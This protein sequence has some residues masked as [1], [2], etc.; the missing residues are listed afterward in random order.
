MILVTDD[1]VSQDPRSTA[2]ANRHVGLDIWTGLVGPPDANVAELMSEVAKAVKPLFDKFIDFFD[3]FDLSFFVSGATFVAAIA[4]AGL[5]PALAQLIGLE[6]IDEDGTWFSNSAVPSVAVAM[7]VL[8]S[9][10]SGMTCFALGRFVRKWVYR[11]KDRLTGADRKRPITLFDELVRHGML[12]RRPSGSGFRVNQHG[13][14]IPWLA[15]YVEG[16]HVQDTALYVRMWAEVRQ[17]ERLAPS[18]SLLRR[19]WVSAATLDGLF[20]AF[21]TWALLL[22]LDAKSAPEWFPTFATLVGAAFC[23]REAQRYGVFQREELI[24]TLLHAYDLPDV[25]LGGM[26]GRVS[27]DASADS[28]TAIAT[29]S[30]TA[31]AAAASTQEDLAANSE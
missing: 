12:E 6:S 11:G 31:V 22:A 20:V 25:E 27:S 24:A 14:R 7:L 15:R 9:Y 1:R 30:V 16:E 19:Y 23:L 2:R 3:I 21:G 5:T 4:W 8:A 28:A 29:A 18:F 17:R 26:M 10:V 13:R